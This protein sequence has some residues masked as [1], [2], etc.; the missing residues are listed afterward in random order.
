LKSDEVLKRDQSL[1][2]KEGG[3]MTVVSD[4][5][6]MHV[7]E[8]FTL[9][10]G[11]EGM[12]NQIS[13]IYVC[14]ENDISPWVQGNEV[15]ILYGAAVQCDDASMVR[16]ISE[17]R[18]C[19]IAAVIVLV[20]QYIQDVSENVIVRAD[21]ERIPLIEI[22]SEVPISCITKE[23][24][25][26]IMDKENPVRRSGANVLKSV[27]E[28]NYYNSESIWTVLEETGYKKNDRNYIFV[29][30]PEEEQV[31]NR[32]KTV[33]QNV[34]RR[35]FCTDVFYEEGDLVTGL[36]GCGA[37]ERAAD[38]AGRVQKRLS[39]NY[40]A[41]CRIGIGDDVTSKTDFGMSCRNAFTALKLGGIAG[42]KA[43]TISVSDYPVMLQLIMNCT[44]G[45]I[46]ND[47]V[48]RTVAP[49]IRNDRYRKTELML[50]LHTFM[51]CRGN[52]KAAADSLFIHRNTMAYRI[53]QIEEIT[54]RDMSDL[55]DIQDMM[56]GDLTYRYSLSQITK[57]H[58]L[59]CKQKR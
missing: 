18:K 20:G 22:S 24:A 19:G 48:D 38:I 7:S 30:E 27:L 21:R 5:W 54:G 15:L 26:L 2:I 39:E 57:T 52:L 37:D 41:V 58:R 33:V 29:L 32:T 46:I 55:K 12:D 51:D 13:W 9:R 40:H 25:D 35:E 1:F 4:L 50:S 23:I 11:K 43:K 45:E 53:R 36:F 28:G 14:Q 10:A 31:M 16:F 6:K 8:H 44:S 59:Y 17:C 49:L 3:L 47:I 34:I 56:L 42:E